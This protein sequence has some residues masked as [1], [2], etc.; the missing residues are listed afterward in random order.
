MN[1]L[2]AHEHSFCLLFKDKAV[3]RVSLHLNFIILQLVLLHLNNVILLQL[4]GSYMYSSHIYTAMVYMC[5]KTFSRHFTIYM[6]IY[7][8]ILCKDGIKQY[9]NGCCWKAIIRLSSYFCPHTAHIRWLLFEVTTFLREF[10]YLYY[11]IG[12]CVDGIH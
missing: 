1:V 9:L 5:I 6:Y 12:I 2:Q 4:I 11:E 10:M 3:S 7:N 8:Q